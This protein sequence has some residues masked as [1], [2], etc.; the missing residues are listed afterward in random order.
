MRPL[1]IFISFFLLLGSSFAAPRVHSVVLG[2]W[3]AVEIRMDSGEKQK[4]KIRELIIDGRPREYTTGILHEVTD[5]LFVVRRAYRINDSLPEE[6]KPQQW[7]WRLDGWISVDRQTGHVAQLNLPAFDGDA[8]EA[9]WYRDYAAYCGASDDGSKSYL[10]VSQ[11]GRRKPILRKEYPG[12]ACAAPR[13]ERSPSR[14]TFTT[15]GEKTSFVV[16]AHSADLQPDTTE[17]EG[18]Q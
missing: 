2:Q 14:V 5:R 16:H 4:L 9:S 12:P 15:A 13:W 10:V 8:S 1:C 6:K 11:L 17:E 18:P 7:V 3:R